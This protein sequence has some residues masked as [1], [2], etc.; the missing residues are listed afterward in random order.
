[1]LVSDGEMTMACSVQQHIFRISVEVFVDSL[2]LF[3]SVS[4]FHRV[5]PNLSY[6]LDLWYFHLDHGLQHRTVSDLTTCVG[7]C[8]S[9]ETI[10]I[11]ILLVV[12]PLLT[13]A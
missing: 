9:V 3:S 4:L 7:A 2:T 1:M 5:S 11:L 10:A 6:R 8:F 13:P 12:T